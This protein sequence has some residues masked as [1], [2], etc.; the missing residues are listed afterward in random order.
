[1][2]VEGGGG[3]VGSNEGGLVAR[4]DTTVGPSKPKVERHEISV[5]LQHIRLVR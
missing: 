4:I 2:L 1:M 5:Y 3:T